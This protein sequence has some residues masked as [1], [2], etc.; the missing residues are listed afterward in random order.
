MYLAYIEQPTKYIDFLKENDS[1]FTTVASE[2][3]EVWSILTDNYLV[4]ENPNVDLKFIELYSCLDDVILYE[5]LISNFKKLQN[6]I[7]IIIEKGFL[8]N[9]IVQSTNFNDFK[10]LKINIPESLGMSQSYVDLINKDWKM[11]EKLL[12]NLNASLIFYGFKKGQN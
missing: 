5:S 3:N 6:V 8:D 12:S 4:E 9:D 2:L 1:N 10:K 11:V 7:N